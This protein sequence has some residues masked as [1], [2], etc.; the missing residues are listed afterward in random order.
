[1]TIFLAYGNTSRNLVEVRG[2]DPRTSR[3]LSERSTIWA[4]KPLL[5][6]HFAVVLHRSLRN[7]R[8]VRE[9]ER[10]N[11]GLWTYFWT[12]VNIVKYNVQDSYWWRL[13]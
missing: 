2:I 7:G 5:A 11:P 3:M 4:K 12:I 13:N 10:F 1:M 8:D 9:S 6:H